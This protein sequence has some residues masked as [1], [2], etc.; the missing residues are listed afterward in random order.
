M[1]GYSKCK[2]SFSNVTSDGYQYCL[3]CGEAKLAPHRHTWEVITQSDIMRNGR[4]VG[5]VY[6]IKCTTCGELDAKEFY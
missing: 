4:T 2:H 5:R 3:H 1:F 6:H